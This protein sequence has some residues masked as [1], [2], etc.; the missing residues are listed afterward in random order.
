MVRRQDVCFWYDRAQLG[1]GDAFRREIEAQ[2]DRSQLAIL[3]VSNGFLESGFIRSVELPRIEARVQTGQMI[4]IPIITRL[5]PWDEIDLLRALLVLPNKT[6]PL[7]E[8]LESE[9]AFLKIKD[10]ILDAVRRQVRQ[11]REAEPVPAPAPA[12]PPT[13]PRLP[14]PEPTPPSPEPPPQ[15]PS[16]PKPAPRRVARTQAAS[17][18]TAPGTTNLPGTQVGDEAIGPDGGIFIWVPPGEFTIGSEDGEERE[19]PAHRVRITRGLWLGKHQVTNV[20]YRAFCEATGR[21][22]P[23]ESNQGDDHPVVHV[24]WVDAQAYCEHF[25]LVLPTEAQWE[26][27][28]AGPEGRRYP[29]GEKWDPAKCCRGYNR[30][31]GGRTFPVGR[32]ADGASWCGALDM[33]GNVWEWCMDRSGKGYYRASPPDDPPGPE[34]GTARVVRGGAWSS[35]DPAGFRCTC[36]NFFNRDARFNVFGFRCARGTTG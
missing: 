8:Y 24:S 35:L 23:A 2:I 21:E 7:I 36:R 5:C 22:F 19:R 9:A 26:Y 33:A 28:A 31:P 29:W 3:P 13:A 16:E 17:P 10:E 14:E 15:A 32:F 27:A 4:V 18:A 25:G 11:I 20:R 1:A 34:H 30:G 12:P 6:M